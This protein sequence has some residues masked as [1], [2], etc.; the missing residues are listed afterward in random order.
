M[1][2]KNERPT[3][4]DEIEKQKRIEQ[5]LEGKIKLTDLHPCDLSSLTPHQLN[6]S[7]KQYEELFFFLFGCAYSIDEVFDYTLP[8]LYKLVKSRPPQKPKGR[9]KRK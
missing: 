1:T 2:K 9:S 5:Y 4:E 8:Q 7:R 3:V 6:I